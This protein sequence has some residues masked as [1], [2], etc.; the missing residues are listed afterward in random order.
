MDLAPLDTWKIFIKNHIRNSVIC[1]GNI[2]FSPVV[3]S[4]IY[5]V[6]FRNRQV[7]PFFVCISPWIMCLR[8]TPRF[9]LKK[10]YKDLQNELGKHYAYCCSLYELFLGIT[11]LS[12]FFVGLCCLNFFSK[13]LYDDLHNE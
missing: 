13:K 10:L 2:T 4:R 5:E 12:P 7:L 9:F 1:W 8:G 11:R 3:F 6:T